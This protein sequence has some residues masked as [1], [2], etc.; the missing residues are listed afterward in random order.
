MSDKDDGDFGSFL[1]GFVIGG[2]VGGAVALVLAPRSGAETRS[3]ITG[4]GRDMVDASEERY[5]S[6]VDSA[7]SYA[8]QVGERASQVGKDAEEQARIILDEGLQQDL[9]TADDDGSASSAD[10]EDEAEIGTS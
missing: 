1:A 2:L 10:V 8:H 6:A 5:H 9:S 7:E 4:K 3:Q